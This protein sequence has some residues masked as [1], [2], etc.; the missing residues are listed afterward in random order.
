MA[1]RRYYSPG[2]PRDAPAEHAVAVTPN[3]SV[4][5]A[6]T[7][8]GIFVGGDGNLSVVMAS[9]DTVL[10]TGVTAG[11]LLP[12][13]VSRVRSSSTTATNIVALF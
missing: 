11:T 7:S 5:L 3:A 1:E 4:D 2:A 6:F 10:F 13:S 8:R 9:G 12:V